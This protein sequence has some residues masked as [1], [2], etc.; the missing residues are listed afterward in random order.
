MKLERRRSRQASS[1]KAQSF[2]RENRRFFYQR[3]SAAR[4][5]WTG[6]DQER[7][8]RNALHFLNE[9][10][11]VAWRCDRAAPKVWRRRSAN[12]AGGRP[13][14]CRVPVA[15]VLVVFVS[16]LLCLKLRYCPPSH[17]TILLRLSRLLVWTRRI[18]A[19]DIVRLMF[20]SRSRKSFHF[21][22]CLV[23][24]ASDR[25]CT[26]LCGAENETLAPTRHRCPDVFLFLFLCSTCFCLMLPLCSL[27]APLCSL[28]SFFSM[29][30]LLLFCLGAF[31]SF[32]PLAGGR[33]PLIAF[34]CLSITLHLA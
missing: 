3:D 13:F 23:V 28:S 31:H 12:T 4:K 27:V 8:F 21:Q 34:E 15:H 1:R 22:P 19:C 6:Y 24:R 9:T 25:V 26:S 30:L 33:G 17:F 20:P 5:W 7:E 18:V 10:H 14:R 32:R 2:E 16:S 11:L 29:C